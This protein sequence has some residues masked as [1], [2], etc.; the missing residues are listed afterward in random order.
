MGPA[1]FGD[2]FERIKRD[3][4]TI[5]EVATLAMEIQIQQRSILPSFRPEHSVTS[6][7]LETIQKT[8]VNF[9]AEFAGSEQGS[10]KPNAADAATAFV[11][12]WNAIQGTQNGAPST[13]VTVN[14]GEEEV[15]SLTFV[16]EELEEE[17]EA[18]EQEEIAELL[19]EWEGSEDRLVRKQVGHD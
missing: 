1:I 9:N 13:V 11:A 17:L 16:P 12:E 8:L 14:I 15:E 3:M 4:I 10:A 18:R 5:G 6:M 7:N 19:D 2:E